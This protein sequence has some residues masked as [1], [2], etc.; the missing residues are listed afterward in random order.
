MPNK[1]DSHLTEGQQQGVML[2][3]AA[4]IEVVLTGIT[5][6]DLLPSMV[7]V[8]WRNAKVAPA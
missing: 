1:I 8:Y 2:M 6:L 7:D 4:C 3:L 5:H